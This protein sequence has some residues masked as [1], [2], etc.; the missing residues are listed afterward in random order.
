[1]SLYERTGQRDRALA[2]RGAAKASGAYRDP[3]DPWLDE[4][5]DA[6]FDPY[7]LALAA[8]LAAGRS[9]GVATAVRLLERAIELAPDDVS[10]HFQLGSLAA[11]QKNY[12][13]ARTQL[14]LCTTLAPDFADGWARLSALQVQL[15]EGTAAER[16]LSAGL[17]NCPN[18]PGLHL[19]R[20]RNLLRAERTGEAIN[21]FMISIRLRPNE[22]D[23][24]I[25]LGST[26]VGLGRVDEGVEQ[27]RLALEAD[28]A[29]PT[30]LA[31]LAYSAIAAG[32]EP[33]ARQWLARVALQ[34]R[35]P[36]DRVEQLRAAYRQT[37]GHDW[38]PEKIRE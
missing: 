9:G 31:I 30:A 17:K 28:P 12:Q 23:A 22:P 10:S 14:E 33:E 34:P 21:E 35:V 4:I 25:E 7:R 24:Y 20:A 2:I 18:S 19:M 8:G 27:L 37:F 3:P 11:E 5:L 26:Y 6:C 15:G 29:N 1:M 38:I 32:K 36:H 16:S 13:V